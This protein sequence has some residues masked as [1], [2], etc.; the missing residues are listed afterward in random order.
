M[1]SWVKQQHPLVSRLAGPLC[2]SD[3]HLVSVLRYDYG[4]TWVL[5]SFLIVTKW[6][7]LML[8]C[9]TFCSTGEQ[10]EA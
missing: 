8:L 6:S 10:H 4:V 3:D 9:E 7:C 1:L 5:F 2:C